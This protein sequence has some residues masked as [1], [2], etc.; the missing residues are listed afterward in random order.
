MI[1]LDKGIFY[2]SFDFPKDQLLETT[3][4]RLSSAAFMPVHHNSVIL[5]PHIKR[6]VLSHITF[7]F[8]AIYSARQHRIHRDDVGRLYQLLQQPLLHL[9]DDLLILCLRDGV[10]LLIRIMF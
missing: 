3:A 8:I 2:S 1:F 4:K 5:L 9:G 10:M 6:D 7:L